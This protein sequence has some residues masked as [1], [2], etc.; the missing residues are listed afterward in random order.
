MAVPSIVRPATSMLS[1]PR[2]CT[3]ARGLMVRGVA[4]R[5]DTIS[6][7]FGTT[8]RTCGRLSVSAMN[9]GIVQ[10]VSPSSSCAAG[11][12]R[13]PSSHRV[14][15]SSGLGA[16]PSGRAR[17]ARSGSLLPTTS[18]RM[19]SSSSVRSPPSRIWSSHVA[20]MPP[21]PAAARR[22]SSSAVGAPLQPRASAIWRVCRGETR[23]ADAPICITSRFARA[24]MSRSSAT[25][26]PISAT[27]DLSGA[28]SA[29][30]RR[31]AR[32]SG[33]SASA[34]ASSTT[35]ISSLCGAERSASSAAA[36]TV[37]SCCC[38]TARARRGRRTPSSSSAER[39]SASS[40]P[41]FARNQRIGRSARMPHAATALLFPY[42]AL[43]QISASPPSVSASSAASM[44]GRA[45]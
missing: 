2:S 44:R 11:A 19:N 33:D 10:P 5:V 40:R 1:G 20:R 36:H 31:N 14:R 29:S 45:E 39:W 30:A 12:M 25:R 6:V 15:R 21:F 7:S 8:P 42:P 3:T 37:A 27:R 32:P 35:K 22:A 18:R 16:S 13:S 4:M 43:P 24:A 17:R 9:R 23:R 34:S 26:R 41:R 38:R 28:R